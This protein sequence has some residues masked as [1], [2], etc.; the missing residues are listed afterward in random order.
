MLVGYR[1]RQEHVMLGRTTN[2]DDDRAQRVAQWVG[3]R[4]PY[5]LC[6]VFTGLLGVVDAVT[7]VIGIALGIAA[8]VLGLVGLR[9]LHVR[10][11]LRGKRLCYGGMA[12]VGLAIATSGCVWVMLSATGSSAPS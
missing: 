7:L 9:D 4:S 3:S 6:S 1:D 10:T 2:S 5:A 11:H 8:V 12:L